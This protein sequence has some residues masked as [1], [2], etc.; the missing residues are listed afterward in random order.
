MTHFLLFSN[1]YTKD[2]GTGLAIQCTGRAVGR[3]DDTTDFHRTS[4]RESSHPA[5]HTPF[6]P[7]HCTTLNTLGAGPWIVIELRYRRFLG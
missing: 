4:L 2:I 6:P 7:A 3:E 1:R 5:K